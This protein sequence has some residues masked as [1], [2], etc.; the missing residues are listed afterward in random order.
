[1]PPRAGTLAVGDHDHAGQVDVVIE[2]A[3]QLDGALGTAE[4][5]PV[6]HRGAQAEQHGHKLAPACEAAGVALGARLLNPYSK[7]LW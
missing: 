1:M 3:V 6:E 2:Q 4:L 5:G 7:C